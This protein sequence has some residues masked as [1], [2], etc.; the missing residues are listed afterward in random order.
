MKA[1]H[2]TVSVEVRVTEGT[3]RWGDPAGMDSFQF[4]LPL[5]A[6]DAVNVQKLLPSMLTVAKANFT[7]N[8]EKYEIEHALV[9]VS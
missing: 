5:D 3:S 9:E 2:V 1:T 7:A 8:A 6:L 4:T